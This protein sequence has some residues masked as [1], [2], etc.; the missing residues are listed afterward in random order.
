MRSD[1]WAGRRLLQ[2]SWDAFSWIVAVPVALLLRYDFEP[3]RNALLIGLVAGAAAAALHLLTGSVFHLYRGRYVVGSFDEVFGVTMTTLFV[4]AVG[5]I[6]FFVLPATEFP[7]STFILATGIATG[8]MLGARFFW[9][10]ARQQSALRREGSRTLIYGAGDAGSQIVNLMLADRSGKFQP[11]GFIDDDHNKQH[12]RRYGIRV[13]GTVADLDDLVSSYAVDTVLVAI[14]NIT[15]PRL[16]DLDRQCNL[17]G[18]RVQ[19]IPTA[20]EI[21]G[22]AVKL[23]DISDVTEEDLMGRRPIHTDEGQ[24][25][26]FIRGRRVLVT[27]AGGSI[28]SELA[29]QLARYA[30]SRLVLLDRDESAL[31]A[32]QLTLDGSGTLTSQDLYLADIRDAPRVREVFSEVA[33]EIVFHAAALKHLPLLER[34]PEEALKTNVCGTENVLAAAQGADVS[35]FVNISTDK[36][37]DP[38]SVLGYSKLITERVTAGMPSNGAAK[39]VSVRFGNVLGSRGSVIETFRY[40]ISHGGPVTVTDERVTR[41]FMTVSEA[42]HLVL[43]ASVLGRHGETLILDM[44]SPLAIVEIARHM[45]QRSGRDIDIRFTGLRP[46]EKLDEV[47]V[48]SAESADRPLHPLISHT[49]VQGTPLHQAADLVSGHDPRALLKELSQGE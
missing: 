5:S 34:F 12:L 49:S 24:I 40:Q 39:Y 28:G 15:A 19:V 9:R 8:S 47:L 31:H 27:G 4:G 3:P 10:G 36:A 1:T 14:A 13:L 45:I 7:R 16:L 17:L 42:V 44:G 23:G 46:G 30:P 37:A 26:D 48:A 25:T 35:V 20:S 18:V 22:G 2:A 6:V 11:V 21:V 29:R 41:Y 32:V 33:P 43:Q 38:T